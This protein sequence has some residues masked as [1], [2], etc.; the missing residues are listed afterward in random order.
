MKVEIVT[1]EPRNRFKGEVVSANLTI[2]GLPVD[3]SQIDKI[4]FASGDDQVDG[5]LYL[6]DGTFSFKFRRGGLFRR[7]NVGNFRGFVEIRVESL[8]SNIKVAV[9]ELDL[10]RR[11]DE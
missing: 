10:W 1:R 2:N 3:F 5:Q 9:E 7:R 4:E 11:I 8:Q 6:K